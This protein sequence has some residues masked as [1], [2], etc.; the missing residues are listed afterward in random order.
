MN[1][2]TRWTLK[3]W[4][5]EAVST[6]LHDCSV[7]PS[8]HLKTKTDSVSKTLF[9][10]SYLEFH[11][12]VHKRSD[13]GYFYTIVR[14]FWNQHIL[15]FENWNMYSPQLTLTLVK[16]IFS[17]NVIS[18]KDEDKMSDD[19]I[20]LMYLFVWSSTFSETVFLRHLPVTWLWYTCK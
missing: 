12:H 16:L 1:H 15:L 3:Y 4:F 19:P 2:T 6:Q 9:F 5:N 18:T 10:F 14:T 8:L 7:P 17:T 13:S 11:V 20:T